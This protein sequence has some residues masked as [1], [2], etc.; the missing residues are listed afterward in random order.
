MSASGRVFRVNDILVMSAAFAW[1]DSALWQLSSDQRVIYCW[2]C[3]NQPLVW[4][5]LW[6]W[7]HSLSVLNKFYEYSLVN[8]R[9]FLQTAISR[10]MTS[11]VS[12]VI[13]S[14]PGSLKWLITVPSSTRLRRALWSLRNF[15]SLQFGRWRFMVIYV[16]FFVWA[17][18]ADI[19][20]LLNSTRG[21]DKSIISYSSCWSFGPTI[22]LKNLILCCCFCQGPWW[23]SL[24]AHFKTNLSSIKTWVLEWVYK[25]TMPLKKV[26]IYK[27]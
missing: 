18:V 12:S 22:I 1:A 13:G 27:T 2:R 26:G 16:V 15:F 10:S 8:S 3:A 23:R 9:G 25:L 11:P 5:Q 19:F 24:S 14:G 7:G 20:I 6:V 17:R 4:Q 21:F